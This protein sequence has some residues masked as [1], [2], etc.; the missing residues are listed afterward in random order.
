MTL[1]F[2]PRS[3][4]LHRVRCELG[5]VEPR[6]KPDLSFDFAR[7]RLIGGWMFKSLQQLES[8]KELLITTVLTLN[9][10]LRTG[11][12]LRILSRLLACKQLLE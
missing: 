7:S 4:L 10:K 2:G 5:H 6:W 11:G 9:W 3:V 8:G 1:R 12:S